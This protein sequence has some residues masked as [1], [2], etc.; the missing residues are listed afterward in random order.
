MRQSGAIL[1][2]S[3]PEYIPLGRVQAALY[4][5]DSGPAPHIAFLVAH[6]TANNLSTNACTELSKRG[7]M[8]L[9]FNTRFINNE[10]QVRWEET[11][12][13]VKGGRRFRT[14]AAGHHQGHSAGSF[15]RLAVDELYEAIAENGVAYCQ[16]PERIV[17]CGNNVGGLTPVDGIVFPTRIPEIR[18]RR[19]AT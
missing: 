12:L 19:C 18:C 15:G 4:K 13:D 14:Q 11:P 5:P 1:A 9:C 8:V 16:K 17:K 3:H 10:A 7:F 6:R 2:Q